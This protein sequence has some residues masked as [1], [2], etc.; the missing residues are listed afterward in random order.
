MRIDY[1][2]AA[3]N[4]WVDFPKDMLSSGE[5]SL[6]KEDIRAANKDEKVSTLHHCISMHE[7]HAK[8]AIP[9]N[10]GI[11]GGKFDVPISLLFCRRCY[12]SMTVITTR[13]CYLRKIKNLIYNYLWLVKKVSVKV[14]QEPEFFFFFWEKRNCTKIHTNVSST[15]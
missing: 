7:E 3:C 4:A 2:E 10:V 14:L 9:W 12:W 15:K 11:L 8:H 6:S 1:L 5:R 13:K